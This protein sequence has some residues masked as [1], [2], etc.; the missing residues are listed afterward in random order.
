MAQLPP[1][2]K[3]RTLSPLDPYNLAILS[4][5]INYYLACTTPPGCIP[6]GYEGPSP[7]DGGGNSVKRYCRKCNAFKPPRTHHCSVCKTCVLRMDHH[8]PWL[9]NCVGFYNQGYFIRF[10]SSVGF[11]ASYCLGL[12]SYKNF[13]RFYSPPPNSLTLVV[14]ILDAVVLFILVLTVGLLALWQLYYAASNTTTIEALENEKI[15]KLIKRGIIRSATQYPY[16]LGSS[17]A[18]L[19][20]MLGRNMLLW[21]IPFRQ[22]GNGIEFPM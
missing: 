13:D 9:N 12:Y 5:W 7:K 17:L 21:W 6:H 15:D 14:M 10:I 3:I 11:A 18:N 20:S 2:T 4:I 8:C 22:E 1:T 16:D 19:K